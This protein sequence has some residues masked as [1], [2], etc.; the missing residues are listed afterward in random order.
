[1]KSS[2][3][4]RRLP[5]LG[6]YAVV[7]LA[8]TLG[9]LWLIPA[10]EV[11]L[12]PGSAEPTCSL[13]HVQGQKCVA[14]SGGLYD[15]YVNELDANHLLYLVLA[16]F[17]SDASVLPAADVTGNCPSQ[18]YES[19]LLEDMA[20]S[21][22]D[23]EAAAL[24]AAGYRVQS[25]NWGPQVVEIDCNAPA[26]KVLQEG[27]R[28]IAVS[29][30]DINGKQVNG[31]P[32]P[33]TNLLAGPGCPF[34]NQV[35]YYENLRPPG[36]TLDLTILRDGKDRNVKV[37]TISGAGSGTNSKALI[38][39][40]MSLPFKFPVKVNI[41]TGDVGGPSAGLAFTLGIYEQLTHQNLTNGNRVAVTGTINYGPVS[42]GS[43]QIDEWYVGPIGGAEQKAIAA[44]KAGAQYFIV[45][46]AAGNAQQARSAHTKLKIYPVTTLTQAIHILKSLP[47]AHTPPGESATGG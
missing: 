32:W 29:G 39:I 4:F 26:A 14:S 13:I 31:K 9:I 27:D 17:R 22:I 43:R 30:H 2:S 25:E 44:Q 12:L 42:Q 19:Q 15:T 18:E 10:N 24:S 45:P 40:T 8:L 41:Q 6:T 5:T 23:A 28:I 38:G 33:C 3:S 20:D 36:S 47:P 37:Q 34:F 21:K 35:R 16:L 11:I 1:M 46:Q 7:V